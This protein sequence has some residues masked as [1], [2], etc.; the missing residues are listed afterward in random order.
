MYFSKTQRDHSFAWASRNRAETSG[1]EGAL[2]L[3]THFRTAVRFLTGTVGRFLIGTAG[4]PSS[5]SLLSSQ[6]L[7][8]LSGTTNPSRFP[9]SSASS[10]SSSS[11]SE[12]SSSSSVLISDSSE[13]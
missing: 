2:G 13:S 8:L 6:S 4:F 5:S 7:S 9:S 12:K 1:S 3:A 10:S 11:S